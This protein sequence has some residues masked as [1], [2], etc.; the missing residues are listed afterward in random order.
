MKKDSLMKCPKC[1]SNLEIKGNMK[2]HW[3]V[4]TGFCSWNSIQE[5]E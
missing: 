2:N 1:G 3:Y 5:E 4:C